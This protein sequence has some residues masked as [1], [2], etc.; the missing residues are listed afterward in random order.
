MR[1]LIHVT[2]YLLYVI[3]AIK[4]YFLR[5][6]E[7]KYETRLN[8]FVGQMSKLKIRQGMNAIVSSVDLHTAVDLLNPQCCLGNAHSVCCNNNEK[9]RSLE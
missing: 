8:V 6:P 2:R 9:V 4:Y 7:F 3:R 1:Y 5:F